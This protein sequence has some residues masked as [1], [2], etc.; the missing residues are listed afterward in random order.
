RVG[1]FEVASPAKGREPDEP[2]RGANDRIR[3]PDVRA[4]GPDEEPAPSVD[5]DPLRLR[6]PGAP[7]RGPPPGPRRA[8]GRLSAVHPDPP[9][10][11]PPPQRGDP[12]GH[13]R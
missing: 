11:A 10:S 4:L 6:P 8:P 2:D 7:R 13:R 12:H 5:A 9:R 3:S 1:P